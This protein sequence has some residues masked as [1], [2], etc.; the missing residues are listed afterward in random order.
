MTRT[1]V[2]SV[3]ASLALA[4]CFTTPSDGPEPVLTP[5][6]PTTTDDLVA[7]GY[8]LGAVRQV[9]QQTAPCVAVSRDLSPRASPRSVVRHILPAAP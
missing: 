9:P 3:A 2:V 4:G 6:A 1:L 8:V 5:D 7:R